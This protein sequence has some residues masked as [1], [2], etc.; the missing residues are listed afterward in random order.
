MELAP[1]ERMDGNAEENGE[2][3]SLRAGSGRS[4]ERR[5][6]YGSSLGCLGASHDE[7]HLLL[8]GSVAAV[9]HDDHSGEGTL[10][11]AVQSRRQR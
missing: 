11:L 2:S 3:F 4:H 6:R 1:A 7:V 9:V 10:G 5:S 8:L